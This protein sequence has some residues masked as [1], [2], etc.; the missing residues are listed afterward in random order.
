M[1][2]AAAL[3]DPGP[4]RHDPGAL[5]RDPP[6][7]LPRPG[8]AGL[9]GLGE[10][11]LKRDRTLLGPLLESFVAAELRKQAS[12]SETRPSLLHFRTLAGREVDLVLEDA[13]GRVVGLEVKA[14][15]VATAS[16]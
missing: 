10:E 6:D 2:K 14:A 12:W 5:P 7:P 1:L 4:S 9:A 16:D 15:S 11:S 13:A 3:Q 8:G